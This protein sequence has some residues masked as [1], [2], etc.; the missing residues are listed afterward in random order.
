MRNVKEMGPM[1]V[2]S[3]SSDMNGV[4]DEAKDRVKDVAEMGSEKLKAARTKFDDAFKSAQTHAV[5]AKRVT[6]ARAKSGAETAHAYVRQE[7]WKAVGLA[8]GV[9]ILAGLLLAR[10][11]EA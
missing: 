3:L 7:P 1:D 10:R 9:G 6:L 11:S 8:A 5:E 2:D 4:M